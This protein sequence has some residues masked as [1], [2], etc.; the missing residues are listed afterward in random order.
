MNYYLAYGSNLNKAQM[1]HRCPGAVAI[2][3]TKIPGYKHVFRRGYLTIE[4]DPEGSVDVG[5]WHI[6]D[7]DE[8]R[9]DV[10]E[11]FPK[12]YHKKLMA[13]HW[14]GDSELEI[15]ALVY[16]MNDGFPIQRSGR[17]YRRTVGQGCK[18]FGIPLGP[19]IDADL[20][21]YDVERS[22]TGILPNF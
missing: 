22:T 12:F 6:T 7:D 13:V 14:P 17:E 3:T 20:D 1:A 18:D 5:I 4:P 21:A 9:L 19:I 15:M 16:I 2:G 8:A 11:G 10:Y